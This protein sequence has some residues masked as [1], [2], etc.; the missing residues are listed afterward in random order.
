VVATVPVGS[1]PV[2]VIWENGEVFCANSGSNSVTVI[3]GQDCTVDATIPVGSNPRALIAGAPLGQVFCA[4]TGSNTVSVIGYE[5]L[6]VRKTLAVGARPSALAEVPGFYVLVVNAG[7]NNVSAIDPLNDTV[8][9]TYP[10]GISP[11]AAVCYSRGPDLR[12]AYVAN[13]ASNDVTVIDVLLDS[14][15][16]TIPVG[17]EPS[18]LAVDSFNGKVYCANLMSDDVSVISCSTNTV[19]ATF[20][21]D[22]EPLAVLTTVYGRT[23][24]A[25]N[26]W[27][28]LT[29]IGDR[30]AIGIAEGSRPA[31]GSRRPRATVVRDL[32]FLPRDMTGTGSAVSDGVPRLSLLDASGRRVLELKPGANDVS[33][34]PPGVYFV[35]SPSPFS[36]PPEGERVG[37]RGR[38]ASIT[39]VI[40]A[41]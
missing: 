19:V 4:N 6:N 34:L 22:Y 7:S 1:R 13:S 36:S 31:V 5:S 16:A 21:A 9:R 37:V 23:Y 24:V 33:A 17:S 32:L 14:V 35:I 30:P 11:V 18:A 25:D 10:V 41:H 20:P 12:L 38:S 27:S 39:K 28:S 40:L 15:V 8:V 2:S 29:V 26:G 3:D